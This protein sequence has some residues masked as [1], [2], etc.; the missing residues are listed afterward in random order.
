MLVVTG[1]GGYP[2]A[3][4]G[5]AGS[6]LFPLMAAT[7]SAYGDVLMVP[8]QVEELR[9]P[10]QPQVPDFVRKPARVLRISFIRCGDGQVSGNLEPYE[11]P[12]TGERIRGKASWR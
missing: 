2:G 6:I 11:D 8:A 10:N 9:S 12:N 5:R 7:D 4:C 1:V 3:Q